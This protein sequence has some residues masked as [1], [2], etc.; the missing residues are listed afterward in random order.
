MFELIASHAFLYTSVPV[1]TA[2][3]LVGLSRH[4]HTVAELESELDTTLQ[5]CLCD[6][7]SAP[8]WARATDEDA[9]AVIKAHGGRRHLL[10]QARLLLSL[11]IERGKNGDPR[12]PQMAEDL[13]Q[14]AKLLKRNWIRLFMPQTHAHSCVEIFADMCAVWEDCELEDHA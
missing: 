7:A 10:K 2:G 14:L 12:A 13:Q 8:T 5:K 6:L 4:A 9:W 3:L 1:A 11:T